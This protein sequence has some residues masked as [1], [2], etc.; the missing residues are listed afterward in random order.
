MSGDGPI[1]NVPLLD[2]DDVTKTLTTVQTQD[3]KQSSTVLL[4]A[5]SPSPTSFTTLSS[6]STTSSLTLPTELAVLPSATILQPFHDQPSSSISTLG[7]IGESK[8]RHRID[9]CDKLSSNGVSGVRGG[10]GEERDALDE[11]SVNAAVSG[12]TKRRNQSRQRPEDTEHRSESGARR[13]GS[14]SSNGEEAGSGLGIGVEEPSGSSVLP[15][16]PSAGDDR[17]KELTDGNDSATTTTTTRIIAEGEGADPAQLSGTT[18]IE[19]ARQ[20]HS[21]Y[22]KRAEEEEQERQEAS[23]SKP[24]D[25][26]IIPCKRS[27]ADSSSTCGSESGG[28]AAGGIAGG[29]VAERPDRLEPDEDNQ[30]QPQE[31][32]VRLPG[33]DT[34]DTMPVR[35][36]IV[37]PPPN[38]SKQLGVTKSL[39]YN[40]SKFRGS[41]KSKGNAYEVEVVLQHVDEANSYLCGYLKITGLTFEFPTL[42]TFFDGEI[43]SRK[44]PFLTRKWDADEDVDRKHF[45]KFAA[46]SEYQKTFNSDDFD[47]DALAKSDYVFMRWKE[48]FLVPDHKIKNING[49]SFA[50]FYYICFQKSQAV[51]EG[52]YY[53]RS[54]EWY[55][56]LTLQHVAESCIQIYEFR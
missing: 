51:M 3:G 32:E 9:L 14:T 26:N 49:A 20:D 2:T 23:D 10:G 35:V 50:G 42:T 52:Y 53:H 36:D 19:P 29:G 24:C 45:G 17:S 55:Q 27:S 4:S 8:G 7:A 30:P 22:E 46:F 54:S 56:S 28:R 38:N 11:C 6:S 21:I 47:Y 34:T 5:E 40:G 31:Q 15:D 43:I 33:R 16:L 39:L 18:E 48:H 37:P 1:G 44:Y 41:Q 13:T 12:K 25:G